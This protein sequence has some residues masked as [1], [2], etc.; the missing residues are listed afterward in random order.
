MLV[1]IVDKWRRPHHWCLRY[2][3]VLFMESDG[4]GGRF[5]ERLSRFMIIFWRGVCSLQNLI[6]HKIP[7]RSG[8]VVF[9]ALNLNSKQPPE[10][11][12]SLHPI[13]APF[14]HSAPH[15]HASRV[16]GLLG[17]NTLRSRA[18]GAPSSLVEALP[19]L[20]VEHPLQSL[21]INDGRREYS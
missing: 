5:G 12:A 1:G 15:H 17:S 9:L 6:G 8:D 7:S 10:E 18:Q 16:E 19:S 3:S 11:N 2:Y 13:L 21:C 4:N 20:L 14:F